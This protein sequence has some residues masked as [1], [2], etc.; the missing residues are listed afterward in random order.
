MP[1]KAETYV[2]VFPLTVKPSDA[3]K[4]LDDEVRTRGLKTTKPPELE[5]AYD[6]LGNEVQLAVFKA[7][8]PD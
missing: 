8:P 7:F 4:T 1:K 6:I 2:H 5:V 3:Q